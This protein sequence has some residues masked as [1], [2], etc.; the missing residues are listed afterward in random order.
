M[1][2]VWCSRNRDGSVVQNGSPR[3]RRPCVCRLCDRTGL[4]VSQW[5]EVTNDTAD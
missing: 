5:G 1:K 2:A 3:L 4:P